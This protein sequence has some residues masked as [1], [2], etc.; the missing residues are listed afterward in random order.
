[1]H[2]LIF[3]DDLNGADLDPYVRLNEASCF[4]HWSLIRDFLSQKVPR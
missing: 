2:N 4:T 3:L 1:M